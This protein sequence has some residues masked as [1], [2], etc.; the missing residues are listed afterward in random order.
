MCTFGLLGSSD[1]RRYS[2]LKSYIGFGLV[3]LSVPAFLSCGTASR[4]TGVQLLVVNKTEQAIQRIQIVS[5][6]SGE[7]I[8]DAPSGKCTAYVQPAVFR[9]PGIVRATLADGTVVSGTWTSV[10]YS[11]PS[12][13]VDGE[14]RV[15]PERVEIFLRTSGRVVAE[16]KIGQ[17]PNGT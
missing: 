9:R 3:V 10:D 16:E 11:D 7:T 17:E 14:L 2:V 6:P 13:I 5:A 1:G 12:E 8:F 15:E 4:S